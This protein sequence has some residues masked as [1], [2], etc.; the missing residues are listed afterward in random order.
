VAAAAPA[1]VTPLVLHSQP[2][3]PTFSRVSAVS[4]SNADHGSSGD[5]HGQSSVA[6][7]DGQTQQ[8]GEH[9]GEHSGASLVASH[10]RQEA[11]ARSAASEPSDNSGESHGQSGGEN[12]GRGVAATTSNPVVTVTASTGDGASAEAPPEPK[13]AGDE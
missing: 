4:T 5:E 8:Q 11:P 12:G 6:H 9:D 3:A 13:H 10:R 1:V 7:G 2:A